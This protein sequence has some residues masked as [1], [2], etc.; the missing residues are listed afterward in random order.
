M[1]SCASVVSTENQTDLGYESPPGVVET[2]PDSGRPRSSGTQINEKSLRIIG[3][4]SSARRTRRGVSPVPG[5]PAEHAELP[6]APRVDARARHRDGRTASTRRSS[7]WA[8]TTGNFYLYRAPAR[9][10]PPGSPSS[11][12]ISR[13]GA[14]CAPSSRALALRAAAVGRGRVRHGRPQRLRGLRGPT[15]CTLADPG[16]NP[17]NLAAVQEVS[18]GIFA[19]ARR[20]RTDARALG[21]RHPA[22]RTGIGDGHR[23]GGGRAARRVRRRQRRA[24]TCARTDSSGR[25]TRIRPTGPRTPCSWR[26]NWRL[27]RFLP[28]R[29]GLAVPLTVTYARTGVRPAAPHRAPTFGARRSRGLRK[30]DSLKHCRYSLSIRRSQPGKGLVDEGCWTHYR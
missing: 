16:I 20:R 22:Q 28:T 2:S 13:P 30:P 19:R 11:P 14:G 12:S 27:D 24:P 15:W 3:R 10:R 5:R 6:H 8:A 29:L 26:A 9:S 21:G 4:P 17:P 1:R 25:S 23:H 18:P 7:S